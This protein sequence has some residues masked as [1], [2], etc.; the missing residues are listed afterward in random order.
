MIALILFIAFGILFGY[1]STLNTGTVSVQFG[2][3]SVNNI[4]LYI[5]VLASLG[6]GVLFTALFYTLKSLSYRFA[7]GKK[8]RDLAQAQKEIS[9]L[10]R[11]NHQLELE[12]ARLKSKTG[13]STEDEDSI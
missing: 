1:F 2:T 13:E 9:S 7:F 3:S 5:L 6:V 4:P 10:T 8:N 12:I 11:E